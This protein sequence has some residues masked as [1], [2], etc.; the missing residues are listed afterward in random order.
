ML[1]KLFADHSMNSQTKPK[2]R[3]ENPTEADFCLGL[4]RITSLITLYDTFELE[5]VCDWLIMPTEQSH[6]PTTSKRLL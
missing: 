2:R 1:C 6:V 3:Q 5:F 4:I